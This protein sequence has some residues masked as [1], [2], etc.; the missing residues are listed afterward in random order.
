MYCSIPLEYTIRGDVVVVVYTSLDVTYG[1]SLILIR[2]CRFSVRADT[3]YVVSLVEHV[4]AQVVTYNMAYVVEYFV[5]NLVSI[6][7]VSSC[8][9]SCKYTL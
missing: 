8:K 1:S 6:L 4:V 2:G 3:T 5:L 9:E 7:V